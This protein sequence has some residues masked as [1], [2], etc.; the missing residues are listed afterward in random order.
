[1]QTTAIDNERRST[2]LIMSEH[3]DVQRLWRGWSR[4]PIH[5]FVEMD[6]V[7][8]D[9]AKGTVRFSVPFKTKYR[10]HPKH[11]GYHGGVLATIVDVAADFALTLTSEHLGL[12]TIDLRVDYLRV[13]K[14]SGLDVVAR[15]LKSGRTIG[16]ADVEV[17]DSDARLCVVGRGTYAMI[18]S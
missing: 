7:E 4:T 12:P 5:D 18:S 14:D 3:I 6:L 8:W 1:M 17:F 2:H 10:R 11:Q 15:T 16:V 13:A 9:Q